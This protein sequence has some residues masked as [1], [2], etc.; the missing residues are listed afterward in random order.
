MR[1]GKYTGTIGN[2]GQRRAC[3]QRLRDLI[4][5]N[6]GKIIFKYCQP[7][8]KAPRYQHYVAIAYGYNP[9]EN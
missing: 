4:R 5:R 7:A 1:P 6:I 3:R 2:R 8:S 9:K